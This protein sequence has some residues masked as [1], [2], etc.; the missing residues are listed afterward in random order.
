M[1]EMNLLT[2]IL[3]RVM[4]GGTSLGGLGADYGIFIKFIL[5]LMTEFNWLRTGSIFEG[6]QT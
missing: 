5:M 1:K 4:K 3:M 2:K 6:L